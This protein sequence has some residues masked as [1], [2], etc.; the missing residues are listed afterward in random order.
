MT[1]IGLL[2]GSFNPIHIGHLALANYMRET[3]AMDEIWLVVSPQNPFKISNDLTSG[4]QRLRMVQIAL[5]NRPH[6]RACDVEM[7]MP[8]P[9]FTIDTLRVLEQQHPDVN[10]SLIM[11]TDIIQSIPQWRNG[12]EIVAR[13]R[14]YVYPRPGYDLPDLE[15][16]PNVVVTDA[17]ML[18][19]SSTFIRQHLKNGKDMCFYLP[20]GVDDYIRE[21]ALY[22]GAAT[23]R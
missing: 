14:L 18:D 1:H 15:A 23:S 3:Q 7:S 13:Y 2:F 6:Y 4:D 8:V 9:S 21:H 5:R 12:Q 20:A 17:P 16:T 11:G 10:F 22:S 19:V